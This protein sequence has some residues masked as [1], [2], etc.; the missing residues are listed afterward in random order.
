MTPPTD[1]LHYLGWLETTPLD[2]CVLKTSVFRGV[3]HQ[4]LLLVMKPFNSMM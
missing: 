3:V 1:Y 2:L 4:V